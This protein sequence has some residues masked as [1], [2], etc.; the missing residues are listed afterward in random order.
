VTVDFA[1]LPAPPAYEKIPFEA[2]DVVERP[3]ISV[4]HYSVAGM[5]I[6]AEASR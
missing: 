1:Y 2:L 4:L 3:S 5:S 6:P